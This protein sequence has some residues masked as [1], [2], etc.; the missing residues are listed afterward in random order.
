MNTQKWDTWVIWPFYF[1]I[2]WG[3]SI[4]FHSGCTNSHPS[5]SS[6]INTIFLKITTI[7]TGVKWFSLLFLIA[8]TWR[9]F[10]FLTTPSVPWVSVWVDPKLSCQPPLLCECS[11]LFSMGLCFSLKREVAT[12]CDGYVFLIFPTSFTK[13]EVYPSLVFDI[14]SSSLS[15][16]RGIEPLMLLGHLY[17][18]ALMLPPP[19]ASLFKLPCECFNCMESTGFYNLINCCI[20][21]IG[22]KKLFEFQ[23]DETHDWVN[24][25]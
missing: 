18:T 10:P 11:A 21:P 14:K 22:L 1:L 25:D 16:A 20:Y 6:P 23:Y 24:V 13:R 8:Q 2:P 3:T 7:L 9:W 5:T 19:A 15:Q 4:V 17:R 12:I